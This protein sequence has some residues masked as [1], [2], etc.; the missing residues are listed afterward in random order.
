M[1][2]IEELVASTERLLS[3]FSASEG[4]ER[5]YNRI[6]HC[7]R[8][9]QADPDDRIMD[10]LIRLYDLF[11]RAAP[12][13]QRMTM[14]LAAKSEVDAKRFLP[15]VFL[16]FMQNEIDEAIASTAAIDLLGYSP[17]DGAGLPVTFAA[18]ESIV[19]NRFC[20]VPGA[21][22]GAAITWGDSNLLPSLERLLNQL[23]PAD[24]NMAARMQT[25]FVSHTTMQ[26]WLFLSRVLAHQQNDEAQS[27][28][29]SCA[30]ALVRLH[31]TA[32]DPIVSDTERLYPSHDFQPPVRVKNWWPLEEYGRLMEAQLV[33]ILEAEAPP[34]IFGEVI[35]TWC[36]SSPYAERFVPEVIH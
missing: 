25:G 1:N 17:P 6:W 18:L 14:Y 23:T 15:S 12:T 8:W 19:Q 9:Q 31:Q 29:G 3:E 4:I 32:K 5:L 21:L 13:A 24:M 27:V 16:I 28:L 26:F 7:L 34:K 11:V 36:P 2:T 20:R 33:E 10:L 35:R 30:S 22:F